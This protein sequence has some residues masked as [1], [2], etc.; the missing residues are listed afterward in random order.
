MVRVFFAFIILIFMACD[1]GGDKSCFQTQGSEFS[2]TINLGEFHA[3]RV[4]GLVETVLIPSDVWKMELSYEAGLHESVSYHISD[5]VLNIENTSDCALQFTPRKLYATIYYRD[6]EALYNFTPYG[7]TSTQSL[8]TTNLLLVAENFNNSEAMYNSGFFDL[9]LQADTVSVI[10]N[11]ASQFHLSGS[12]NTAI[13]NLYSGNGRVEAGNLEANHVQ[14]LHRSY[15]HIFCKPQQS[16]T[17]EIRSTGNVYI[18]QLPPD[19]QLTAYHT[20]QLIVTE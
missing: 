7:V 2:E 5:G 1:T 15:N 3:I 8:Q 10:A 4:N 14:I 12:V 19:N 20:G 17:G 11:G 9:D 13:F 6:L 18:P 16:I